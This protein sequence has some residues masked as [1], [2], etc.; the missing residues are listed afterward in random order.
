MSEQFFLY[1]PETEH[2]VGPFSCSLKKEVFSSASRGARTLMICKRPSDSIK[3][4]GAIAYSYQEECMDFETLEAY[5][6]STEDS[7]RNTFFVTDLI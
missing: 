1:F 2:R 4:R 6:S 5:H 7:K 3:N